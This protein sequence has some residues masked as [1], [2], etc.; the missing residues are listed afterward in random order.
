MGARDEKAKED[1]WKLT[2]TKK[3][4]IKGVY[5]KARRRFM[6]SLEGR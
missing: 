2:K 1:V 3:E 4:R 5:I 6:N